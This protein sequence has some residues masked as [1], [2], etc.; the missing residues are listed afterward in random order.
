MAASSSDWGDTALAQA[1]WIGPSVPV[2][3]VPVASVPDLLEAYARESGGLRIQI[4]CLVWMILQL[5]RA[6][7]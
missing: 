2:P 4:S 3:S 7:N 5:Q 6:M 1:E